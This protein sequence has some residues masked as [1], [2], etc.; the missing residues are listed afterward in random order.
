MKLLVSLFIL[1]LLP[2]NAS[3]SL[4][5]KDDPQAKARKAEKERAAIRDMRS[6]TLQALYRERPETETEVAESKAVAVFSNL[7]VNLL[8]VSTAHG[9]G[10]IVDT[11]TGE[12]TFMRMLSVGGG[13]GIGLKDFR[14]VAIFHTNHAYE[15]F[16]TEGWDFSGQGD[17]AAEAMD[18]GGSIDLAATII[19]GVSLYQITEN[20]LALQVTLH[21]TKYYKDKDL[22]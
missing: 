3:A 19:D 17:A 21:G 11:E 1:V 16:M 9:G 22:N 8:L 5:G 15:S 2:F 4:F 10:V 18:Q 14:V 6:E 7:G 20:G 13:L 12:E